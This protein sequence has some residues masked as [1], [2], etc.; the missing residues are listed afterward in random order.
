MPKKKIVKDIRK[1]IVFAIP[2]GVDLEF[3]DLLF[4]DVRFNANGCW[5]RGNDSTIY[6]TIKCKDKSR[7]AH[8]VSYEIFKGPLKHLCCHYC[9]IPACINPNHLFDGTT[10]DNVHDARKKN[11][12]FSIRI[13]GKEK[14]IQLLQKMKAERNK[15][16][17]VRT[18]T[19]RMDLAAAVISNLRSRMNR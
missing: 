7:R 16:Y 6:T 18:L 4:K 3:I 19:P 10:E 12:I 1:L 8:R 17:P 13:I 9:D 2:D 5:I 15:V 14:R 11:R